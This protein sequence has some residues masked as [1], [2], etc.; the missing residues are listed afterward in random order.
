MS[1]RSIGILGLALLLG[2]GEKQA[3]K[4]PPPALVES[5]PQ[6]VDEPPDL[7]PVARPAEVVLT[8][9][10]A[11]P[12]AFVES[13]AKWA[14]VPLRLEDMMPSEARRFAG[15]VLWD[16]PIDTVV[17]LDAFSESKL[18]EPLVVGSIGLKSLQAGL[19][20]AEALQLQTRRLAPG[21]YRVSELGDASCAMAASVGAAPARLVC[22]KD[23]KDVDVLLPYVT[24]GLPS[25]PHSGADFEL[26]AN[27]KPVQ[28]RYG[29]N[30]SALRLF[31]GVAMREAALDVPRFDRALSDAIYGVIDEA[32]NLFNDLDQVRLE[33]RIDSARSVLVG[34][35]ELRLKGD[36]SWTAGTIAAS[37]AAP[38]PASLPRIVPG[39]TMAAYSVAGPAERYSAM[40]RI[41]GELAEGVLEHEKMPEATRKRARRVLDGWLAKIPES[42]AFVVSASQKDE[43]GYLHADTTI[44]RVSE[45]APRLLGVYS[46]FVA[47]LND[48]AVKR[49]IRQKGKLNEKAWPKVSKKPFKLPGFKTPATLFEVTL[50]M[51][52][53]SHGDKTKLARLSLALQPDGDFTYLIAGDD[54]KEMARVMAEHQKAEPGAPFVKPARADKVT[55]AGF[56][57]LAFIARYIER[58]AK[59]P[60]VGKAVASAP[61]RGTTPIPFSSTATAG[62][63]RFDFELPAAAFGDASAAAVRAAVPLKNAIQRR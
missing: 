49:W 15:A 13:M 57:T 36:A 48:P 3:A 29:Q 43:L 45:P 42:F 10:I 56:V 34:S 17:A 59:E 4:A 51:E 41:A 18:P 19:D 52:A 27:A 54:T 38:L 12:R 2:C 16:A 62:S 44:T 47:L 46:D 50:D 8:A 55:A 32:I 1:F 40:G 6:A 11:R 63:A 58:T 31:A 9:R 21:V 14:N 24:R 22:G 5:A 30:I 37:K 60:E 28:D 61:N 25:E 53:L 33:A 35:A 39:A 26:I 20:A 7:S 23:V